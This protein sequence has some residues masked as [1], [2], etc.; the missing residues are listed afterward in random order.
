MTSILP[1]YKIAA[2]LMFSILFTISCKSSELPKD[3]AEPKDNSPMAQPSTEW[4]SVLEIQVLGKTIRIGDKADDVFAV[5]TPGYRI[6]EPTKQQIESG[7]RVTQHYSVDGKLLD[8][9]FERPGN[10]YV[11]AGIRWK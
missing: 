5:L 1:K 4:K 2:L 6:A 7:L 9:T 10:W 11:V 8:V 3:K